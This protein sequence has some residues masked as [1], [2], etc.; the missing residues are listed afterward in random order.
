MKSLNVLL[1]LFFWG[2]VL[3]CLSEGMDI[4]VTVTQAIVKWTGYGLW[5]AALLLLAYRLLP[6]GSGK[7]EVKHPEDPQL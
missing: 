4:S 1:G 6:V 3:K 7:R 5:V 2:M